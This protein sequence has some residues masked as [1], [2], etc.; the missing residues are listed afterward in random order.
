MRCFLLFL[1]FFSVV[2]TAETTTETVD[3]QLLEHRD[4]CVYY[5]GEPFNGV[6]RGF[7]KMG[8]SRIP[9]KN[10]FL[11]GKY[12]R[13][14]FEDK[15]VEEGLYKKG[16]KQGQWCS[17]YDNGKKESEKNYTDDKLNGDQR[18]WNSEGILVSEGYY[19]LDTLERW[20]EW[21][22]TGNPKEKGTCRNGVRKTIN[23]DAR[24]N[25][26]VKTEKIK[27]REPSDWNNSHRRI[28]APIRGEI[29]HIVIRRKAPGVGA[30]RL[31][32]AAPVI[33]KKVEPRFPAARLENRR[34]I[35]VYFYF[36][37]DGNGT[38]VPEEKS[39][40][41][42]RYKEKIICIFFE[43]AI[44]ALRQWRFKPLTICGVARQR[45][46]EI[47][48][49]FDCKTQRVYSRFR[50]SEYGIIRFGLPVY[51][52]QAN[53]KKLRDEIEIELAYDIYGRV[54]DIYVVN[55]THDILIKAA[56]HSVKQW[57]F[58]PY[59]ISG[60]PRLIYALVVIGF[61]GEPGAA[62]TAEYY[63]IDRAK[64]E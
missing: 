18:D 40:G 7:G 43:A 58:E 36:R 23:W 15:K 29:E 25:R 64:S 60:V 53:E 31:L 48:F 54:T 10:G 17:W 5:V 16:K 61:T 9:F 13:F 39:R 62:P 12:L 14:N 56:L 21:D 28:R 45:R 8:I 59:I 41:G 35:T 55:G 20:Q 46:V 52:A 38:V 34:Y 11:D 44:K 1:L 2:S 50:D 30:E 37:I 22:D 42:L 26:S 63:I 27:K 57:I 49:D 47:Q 4:G 6:A 3:F 24:G 51:P 33:R 19:N 32:D